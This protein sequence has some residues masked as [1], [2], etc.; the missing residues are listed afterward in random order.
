MRS[1]GSISRRAAIGAVGALTA[2]AV[3]KGLWGSDSKI[4]S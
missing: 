2:G 3:V 1:P 4:Q